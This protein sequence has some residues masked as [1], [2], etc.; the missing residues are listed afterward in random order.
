MKKCFFPLFFVCASFTVLQISAKAQSS[1][2]GSSYNI[3]FVQ[4][5]P[6]VMAAHENWIN[7]AQGQMILGTGNYV[8]TGDYIKM[9]SP[10]QFGTIP[11]LNAPAQWYFALYARPEGGPGYLAAVLISAVGKT[12]YFLG[13][14]SLQ[15][16]TVDLELARNHGH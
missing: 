11:P 10:A 5:T 14:N 9:L 1:S 6:Q 15:L 4:P 3:V 8:F 2:N 13:Y 7:S 16:S 12:V